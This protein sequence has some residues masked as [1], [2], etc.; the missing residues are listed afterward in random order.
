MQIQTSE[1]RIAQG[2]SLLIQESE[3]REMLTEAIEALPKMERLVIS[4]Y[5][6][7]ELTLKEIESVLGIGEDCIA[8]LKTRAMLKLQPLCELINMPIL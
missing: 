4:L 8:Q 1:N 5:C 3:I 6:Y 2:P 7:E